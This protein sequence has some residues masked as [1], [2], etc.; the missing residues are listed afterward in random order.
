MSSPLFRTR[1]IRICAC[2][3]LALPLVELGSGSPR[4]W[5]ERLG[6]VACVFI[7]FF[8]FAFFHVR[9]CPSTRVVSRDRNPSPT[10]LL[11]RKT[12]AIGYTCRRLCLRQIGTLPTS[13]RYRQ[14]FMSAC[15]LI[16]AFHYG[17]SF[18]NLEAM[19]REAQR[20][21]IIIVITRSATLTR[22]PTPQAWVSGTAKLSFSCQPHLTGGG[23]RG[24]EKEQ[25]AKGQP[26]NRIQRKS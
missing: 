20:G 19:P 6:M 17:P 2:G 22:F 4:V 25:V 10:G 23:R 5:E 9:A 26:T 3:G 24:E 13:P 1:P 21:L 14:I 16:D 15:R 7:F 11:R 8:F 12:R 18:E